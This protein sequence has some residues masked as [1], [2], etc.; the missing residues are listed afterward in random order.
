MAE[1]HVAVDSQHCSGD[2]AAKS[3]DDD[4]AMKR[5]LSVAA[6]AAA[7]SGM[8][9]KFPIWEAGRQSCYSGGCEL[10]SALPVS[11]YPKAAREDEPTGTC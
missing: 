1:G 4:A 8:A 11:S 10:V 5:L 2:T 6:S 7:V 9:K 3:A